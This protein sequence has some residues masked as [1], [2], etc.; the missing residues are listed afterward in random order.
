MQEKSTGGRKA[1][2]FTCA[3]LPRPGSDQHA[4]VFPGEHLPVDWG[5]SRRKPHSR[6]AA[7]RKSLHGVGIRG[8]PGNTALPDLRNNILPLLCHTHGSS[9]YIDLTRGR[10]KGGKRFARPD[11]IHGEHQYRS[12]QRNREYLL[13]A[14]PLSRR[15]PFDAERG[16]KIPPGPSP[17][18]RQFTATAVPPPFFPVGNDAP[19]GSRTN[20]SFTSRELSNGSSSPHT[21]ASPRIRYSPGGTP[22]VSH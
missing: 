8:K 20:G 15:F 9:V 13:H 19:T 12:R 10:R 6:M 3:G 21:N 5:V 11:K 1:P 17:F 2:L 18:S 4:P 22:L 14:F 16:E 7:E